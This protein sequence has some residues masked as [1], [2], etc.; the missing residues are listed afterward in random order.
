[1]SA[2]LV[3][4]IL[5]FSLFFIVLWRLNSN[6]DVIKYN[7]ST[8]KTKRILNDNNDRDKSLL[9]FEV[10]EEKLNNDI[11]VKNLIKVNEIEQ[12]IL[13]DFL[14]FKLLTFND[15]SK[16]SKKEIKNITACYRKPHPLLLPLTQGAFEPN[17]L[18]NLIKTDPEMTAK[19]INV[20]NS[21]AFSLQ[22]PITSI[23]HAIMFMGVSSVKT[24]AMHFAMQNGMD[25]VDKKQNIAFQKVWTASYLASSLCLEL[26]KTLSKNNAAELSTQCILSYLGDMAILS[27]QASSVNNYQNND[28]LYTRVKNQQNDFGINSAIIGKVLAEQWQLPISLIEGIENN[29]APLTSHSLKLSSENL[30]NMLLCYVACRIGD[31]VAFNGL[32]DINTFGKLD[33]NSMAGLAFYYLQEHI[34][35]ADLDEINDIFSD[36]IIKRK[37]NTLIEKIANK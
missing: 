33:V 5:I 10:K 35:K 15:L 31:L 28:S 23:N 3:L 13:D 2:E 14:D 25:F 19:I 12:D 30:Q 4:S 29:L 1:M 18:F 9:N 37:I 17:E 8:S 11:N 6:K 34:A 32:N 16:E 20:V 36:P 27:Y 21:P 26:A 7:P 22:Q 24:I